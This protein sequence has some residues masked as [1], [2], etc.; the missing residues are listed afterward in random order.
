MPVLFALQ[1][2]QLW[3]GLVIAGAL[4]AG[5][6]VPYLL[7]ELRRGKVELGPRIPTGAG[8]TRPGY[9]GNPTPGRPETHAG[10]DDTSTL[11]LRSFHLFLI[12]LSIVLAT[13]T[14]VW[15][16]I[17]HDLVLGAFSLGLALLLVVYGSYFVGKAERAHLE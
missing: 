2:T 16:L 9:R 10:P 5:L 4:F 15:G 11:S 8:D 17:N 1:G 14:G 13:G 7:E 3:L 6:L 12:S